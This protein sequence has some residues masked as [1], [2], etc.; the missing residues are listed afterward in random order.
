MLTIIFLEPVRSPCRNNEKKGVINATGT[1]N[2]LAINTSDQTLINAGTLEDTGSGGLN[3][4][5][6]ISVRQAG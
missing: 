2:P 4:S 6:D 1:F 5:M 3:L